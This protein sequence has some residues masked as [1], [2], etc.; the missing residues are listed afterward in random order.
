MSRILLVAPVPTHPST[1]GTGA[2]VRHMAEGLLSLGHDVHF[3]YVRQKVWSAHD[4]MQRFWGDRLHEFR[5]LSV[6]SCIHRGR[7]KLLRGNGTF[8]PWRKW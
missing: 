6:A 4:G 1:T 5:G 3:L 2:R 7:R 8:G